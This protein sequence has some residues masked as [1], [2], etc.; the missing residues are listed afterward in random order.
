MRSQKGAQLLSCHMRWCHPERCRGRWETQACGSRR[1]SA[2][3]VSV[4]LAG[5]HHSEKWW[6]Q[7]KDQESFISQS[8]VWCSIQE[9]SYSLGTWA[10]FC[11][12]VAGQETVGPGCLLWLGGGIMRCL[13]AGLFSSLGLPNQLIFVL[14][15]RA[16]LRLPLTL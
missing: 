15:V 3:A 4:G 16:P 9:E 12:Q 13:A 7:R 10:A 8:P 5:G 6:L 1:G 2:F 11:C 14:S